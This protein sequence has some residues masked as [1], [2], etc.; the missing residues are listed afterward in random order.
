M[1]RRQ[2]P[3]DA[4]SSPSAVISI[5]TERAKRFRDKNET[6]RRPLPKGPRAEQTRPAL[7]KLVW[8]MRLFALILGKSSAPTSTCRAR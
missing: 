1:F 2:Q 5:Q 6:F 7:F 8:W 4:A 3:H